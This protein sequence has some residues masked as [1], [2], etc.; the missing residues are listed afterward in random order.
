[1]KTT[2]EIEGVACDKCG[3]FSSYSSY[4]CISCGKDFCYECG[5]N[6]GTKYSHGIY[7]SGSGDGFYCHDCD[8]KAR[9]G[10]DP[11]HAAYVRLTM[12][13]TELET[14]SADF[15]KRQEKAEKHLE[16]LA[17]EQGVW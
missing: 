11:L 10:N 13:R 8:A 17:R 2:K 5:E 14:W 15:K 9:A 1:M 7:M 6:A 16:K 4:H 12:L 3:K